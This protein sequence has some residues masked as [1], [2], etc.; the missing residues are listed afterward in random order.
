MLF[1]P[2]LIINFLSVTRASD[3]SKRT[4]L[5]LPATAEFGTSIVIESLDTETP[6][7]SLNRS[8]T[9]NFTA[10][11]SGGCWLDFFLIMS[12]RDSLIGLL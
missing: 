12:W 5:R 7:S 3:S 6:G 10:A 11:I 2:I 4:I 1:W 9:N 8:L